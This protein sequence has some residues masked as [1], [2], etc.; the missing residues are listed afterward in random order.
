MKKVT[1]INDMNWI[2]GY[3]SLVQVEQDTDTAV[4][5]MQRNTRGQFT[6]ANNLTFYDEV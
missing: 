4:M 3:S 1:S 5:P 6:E 2:L